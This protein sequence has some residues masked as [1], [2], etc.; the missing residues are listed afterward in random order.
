[1]VLSGLVMAWRLAMWPTRRSPFLPNATTEGVV[2]EPSALG[3]TTGLPP[4]I[5]AT[6]LLVVPRSM[7]MILDMVY[8]FELLFSSSLFPAETTTFAWRRTFPLAA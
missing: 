5:T 1:M 8:S 6:Q 4:S 2:R 3:M 7:P